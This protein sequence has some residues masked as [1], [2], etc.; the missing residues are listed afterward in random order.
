MKATGLCCLLFFVAHCAYSQT[1]PQSFSLLADP[2]SREQYGFSN[3]AFAIAPIV[4]WDDHDSFGFIA[5][6]GLPGRYVGYA[7][8]RAITSRRSCEAAGSRIDELNLGLKRWLPTYRGEL[9]DLSVGLSLGAVADGNFGM[10]QVQTGWHTQAG[11]QRPVPL[12]YDQVMEIG[13]TVGGIARVGLSGKPS[14]YFAAAGQ[15][16][17]DSLDA[18]LGMGLETGGI[19]LCIGD[20]YRSSGSASAAL[21][22][23]RNV[24]SGPFYSIACDRGPLRLAFDGHPL[25]GTCNGFVGVHLDGTEG[26]R[27]PDPSAGEDLGFLLGST[28]AP[29]FR[30][31]RRLFPLGPCGAVVFGGLSGGWI[32]S[33]ASGSSAPRSSEAAL[34]LS[35]D[36]PLASWLS[37]RG[38]L[39]S[40]LAREELRALCVQASPVLDARAILAVGLCGELRAALPIPGLGLGIK[41]GYAPCRW[42]LVESQTAFATRAPERFEIFVWSD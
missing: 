14:P 42:T 39:E 5:E 3:D 24:E 32:E 30:L 27:M 21:R 29:A 22:D 35:L 4:E 28:S 15:A 2:S 25:T 11:I 1:Q 19:K 17:L 13:P 40:S 12:S 34:G 10:R 38:G 41:G 7:N 9:V 20:D 37:V 23:M 16:G 31:W 33:V 6:T 18:S 36:T 8:L 26:K